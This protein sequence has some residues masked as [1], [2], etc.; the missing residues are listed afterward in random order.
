MRDN[1]SE[2]VGATAMLNE[3]RED[4]QA[5]A[6]RLREAHEMISDL[7]DVATVSLFDAWIDETERRTW[8]LFESSRSGL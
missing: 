2:S 4:N 1:D 3:L 6:G 8:F 5:L 7:R